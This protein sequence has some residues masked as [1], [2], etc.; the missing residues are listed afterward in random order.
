MENSINKPTGS[1][2]VEVW[3]SHSAAK[4]GQTGKWID[5]VKSLKDKWL[6]LFKCLQLKIKWKQENTDE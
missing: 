5:N 1:R 2:T 6:D 3:S 4:L